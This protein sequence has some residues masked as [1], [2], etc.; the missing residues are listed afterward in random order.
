MLWSDFYDG[1]WDWSDSTKRTRIS[2]LENIGSGE[3]IVEVIYEIE[4][5][6]VRSQLIRKAMKMGA[7][8]TSEDF[9]N[10]DGE[11]TDELY[12]ELGKYTGYDH[13]DPYFDEDNMDWDDFYGAYSEW[14]ETILLRR[15]KKLKDFGPSEEVA[16][17]IAN[18]PNSETDELLYKK[19]LASGVKFT[20]E[21]LELMGQWG[22]ALNELTETSLSDEAID[23]FVENVEAI[24]DE[25]EAVQKT[26][27]RVGFWGTVIGLLSGI[28][29]SARPH[30]NGRC[31]GD[32]SSCPAHYGYRY[33]RWYYGHGHQHGCERGGNGGA[34]GKTYRD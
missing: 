6:K 8:F 15:V 10:L 25:Y 26:Q 12:E 16:D 23:Q 9:M 1:F 11:L 2:S 17:A 32:C 14:D 24:A 7:T 28:S 33:G 19:A 13:N 18:M 20:I 21:E 3:E 29:G 27:R 5:P 30:D 31:N 22:D 34:T 4:D